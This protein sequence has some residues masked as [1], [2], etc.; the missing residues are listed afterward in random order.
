MPP[1]TSS[2]PGARLIRMRLPGGKSADSSARTRFSSVGT[3]S[4]LSKFIAM[5]KRIVRPRRWDALL[6]RFA[7]LARGTAALEDDLVKKPS[8]PGVE[9]RDEHVIPIVPDLR[10]LQFERVRAARAVPARFLVTQRAQ[11][12]EPRIEHALTARFRRVRAIGVELEDDVAGGF[13][14]V[15]ELILELQQRLDAIDRAVAGPVFH[16][17][18]DRM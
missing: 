17:R 15:G 4:T 7:L 14:R 18:E 9:R 3:G 2:R 16:L 6:A 11:R 13:R 8:L 12:P 10:I 1:I 5:R